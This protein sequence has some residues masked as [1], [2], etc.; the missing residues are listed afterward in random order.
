MNNNCIKPH[1]ILYRGISINPIVWNQDTNRPSSAAFK[2]SNSL[3]VDREG[4]RSR[5]DIFDSLRKNV[6]NTLKAIA[7]ISAKQCFERN[8]KVRPDPME[9]N[10]YHALIDDND[11]RIGV[12]K[13]NA[14]FL[15]RKCEFELLPI[16]KH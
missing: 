14:R 15:A 9:I 11:S 3:S 13:T 16:D 1:E 5:K 7:W 4:G 2:Q 10:Q 12:G 6:K 8:M